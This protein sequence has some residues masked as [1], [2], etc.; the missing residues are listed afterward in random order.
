MANWSN[1]TLTS[2]YVNYTTEV[3]DRDLDVAKGMDP[4]AVTVTN[5]VANMIRWNSANRYWELYN[6]TSWAALASYYAIEVGAFTG[7]VTKVAGASA[8]TIAAN[9]VTDTKLRDSAALSVV[10]RAI[11]SSG[12]PADISAAADDRLLTRVGA[13]LAW[14]Q[15]TVG[16]APDGIWTYAKIQ[17]VSATD[18][19]LGRASVGAGP[20]EEIIVTAAGRAILDDADA[21]AQRTTLGLG[22]LATQS[23]TFSGTHSGTSSGTNT[24]DQTITLTGDVTG[25][26]T[27][28]FAATIANAAVNQ[29]KLKT[30]TGDVSTGSTAGVEVTLPGGEYGF[31]PNIFLSVAVA[32]CWWGRNSTL[33]ESRVALGTTSP[34]ASAFIAVASVPTIVN[35]R[36]RYIQASPPYNLGDGEVS[37]F[38]FALV[39]SLGKVVATYVAP[40]P[41][42][43]NNGPTNIRP[44]FFDAAGRPFRLVRPKIDPLKLLDP[45]TR[46]A[47]LAKLDAPSVPQE[48]TQAVKQ[49]DMPLIPH[50][51]QGNDLTGKT[52]V[53]LDP[54]AAF[55]ER[56][57]R[58]HEQLSDSGES[59]SGLIHA[60]H[61]RLDNVPLPRAKSPGVIAVAA[62]WKLT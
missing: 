51:F 15:L 26:G 38:I 28:S 39:D 34:L 10:G 1:P 53:L 14:T 44:D 62:R 5:P 57:L 24:G 16:M 3:K 23:G 35:L 31:Y 21:T 4:A 7:D 6:G 42:W 55:T 52:I 8:L 19:M 48:I 25:S 37:L 29:A 50:P 11:N 49:A 33:S 59:L 36:Q 58:M 20:M 47:E 46:N 43:A 2:T 18:R 17:N 41:P 12:D 56:L 40:D 30:T 54:V 13:A 60:D 27:G 61:I 22:T 9:A 45:A 32:D